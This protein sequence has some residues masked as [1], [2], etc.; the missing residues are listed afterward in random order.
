MLDIAK[1]R[2]KWI[3]KLVDSLNQ[4]WDD[5]PLRQIQDMKIWKQISTEKFGPLFELF[6]ILLHSELFKSYWFLHSKK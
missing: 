6:G 2:L 1:V 4:S 5:I 3:T